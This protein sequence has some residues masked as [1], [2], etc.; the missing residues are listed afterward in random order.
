MRVI[1]LTL[2][3]EAQQDGRQTVRLDEWPLQCDHKPYTGMVY[4]FTHNSMV[5]SYLDFPGHIKETDDGMDAENCPVEKLFRVAATVIHLNRASGSGGIHAEE[6]AAACP[7]SISGGALILNALGKLRSDQMEHRSVFLFKDAVRWI[8]DTKIHLIVSD[9]YESR[10]AGEGVF[11]LLFEA[12]ISTVCRPN[13]LHA[14]D[15]PHVKLT[16]LP[17]RWPRVTQLP[18]RVVVELED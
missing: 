8:I 7:Q 13:H 14:I 11:P 6:L 3:V 10:G 5:G 4:H 15:R 1:D 12:G 2:P 18:C 17:V 9:V 16:V